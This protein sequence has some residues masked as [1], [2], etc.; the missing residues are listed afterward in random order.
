MP[1]VLPV[2]IRPRERIL[3]AARDLFNRHGVRGVGVEQ[4]A[5]AAGTNKMTLYR[6]FAS[7]DDLILAYVR[8][9]AADGDAIWVE[10]AAAHPGDPMGQLQAWLV[11][12]AE[13]AAGENQGCELAHAAV[14]LTESDHPARRLIEKLKAY[15]RGRLAALCRAA[16]IGEAEVLADTLTL[17]MEGARVSRLT[18]GGKSSRAGFLHTAKIVI[19]SFRCGSATKSRSRIKATTAPRR[20]KAA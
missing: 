7:K 1:K 11:L 20:R 19:Q 17:L 15:H 16:G 6:H 3:A 9:I 2:A 13:C 4:I 8:D 18:T 12:A 10:F 14:A 5:E